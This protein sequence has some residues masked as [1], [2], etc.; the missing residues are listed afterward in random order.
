[1]PMPNKVLTSTTKKIIYAYLYNP[2][3][4]FAYV[5]ITSKGLSYRDCCHRTTKKLQDK[6]HKL[7]RE[8]PED[9]S[10]VILETIEGDATGFEEMWIRRLKPW[11][12]CDSDIVKGK[13]LSEECKQKISDAHRGV[14]N[15]MY[16]RFG[17][18]SPTSKP[19]YQ[20][21]LNNVFVRKWDCVTDVARELGYSQPN[22]SE[23]CR[24]KRKSANGYVW[25]YEPPK[26]KNGK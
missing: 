22:I 1:M 7:Y 10:L 5:G 20:Y 12:L 21:T 6:F 17:V 24:G 19:V 8:H 14:K 15:P 23:C 4:E 18:K 2:T 3:E 26:E 9:F 11:N 25:R 13:K 16:G